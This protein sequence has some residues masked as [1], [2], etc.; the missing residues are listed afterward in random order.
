MQM[1]QA[2]TLEMAARFINS[3]NCHLFLA[4][5]AGTGN[6][7]SANYVWCRRICIEKASDETSE[8]S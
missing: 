6:T 4:G 7:R 5:K 8:I 1:Q 3:T 2:P